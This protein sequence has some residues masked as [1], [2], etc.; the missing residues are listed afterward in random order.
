MV[1]TNSGAT[2]AHFPGSG[3]EFDAIDRLRARFERAAAARMTGGR[4]PEGETW[5]GDDA[6]VVRGPG[7]ESAL[8]ATDLVV[9]GV[10]VDLGLSGLDDLGYKAL[11]VTVSDLAAMGG[12]PDH[13]L[14]SI[15]A[16]P[17]TD[18]DQVADGV[19]VAGEETG[20]VVVGGDLSGSPVLV[21]SVA[22]SGSLRGSAQLGPLLRSGAKPGDQLLVTGALG[23]SAAG[24]R[25]LRQ[26]RDQGVTTPPAGEDPVLVRA[27]RRPIARLDEGEVA[28]LSG[29]RA[30]I[31][32]S[33]GLVADVRHLARASG[34][35]ID[36]LEVPVVP[37]AT[38]EEALGGGE[39][40]E[41]LLA[42]ADAARLQDEFARAGLR[43]P[44]VIGRCTD[45]PGRL[46]LA[47]GPL[48][49]GGW[50]HPVG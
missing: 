6:A 7:G 44:I 3:D 27:H 1:G 18:L 17:G 11:M 42:T 15:A 38:R 28:R 32:I 50:R 10:H 25:L 34:V 20:C 29:A 46:E 43:P 13:G 31:D 23:G 8:L 16:P 36:L 26:R 5:I 30:A 40:Y 35:G 22:V 9:A 33:D 41:L 21:V 39:D 2:S 14:V 48:P 45:D 19:A 4:P 37:G 24:L 12:R 47:G 49:A